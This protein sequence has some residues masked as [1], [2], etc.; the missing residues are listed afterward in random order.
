M[1]NNTY[2]NNIK[3]IRDEKNLTLKQVAKKTKP[4]LSFG[5]IGNLERGKKTNPTLDVMKNISNAL[6]KSVG[7]VFPDFNKIGKEE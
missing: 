1:M 4:R 3:S 6:G 7:E 5:Y 2:T